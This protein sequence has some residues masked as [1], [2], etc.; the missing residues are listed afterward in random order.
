MPESGYSSINKALFSTASSMTFTKLSKADLLARL[1]SLPCAPL[2]DIKSCPAERLTFDLGSHHVELEMQNRELRESRQLIEQARDRYSDLYDFAPV[3]YLTLD[4]KGFVHEINLTGAEML[5]SN[6]A[7]IIEQ[8]LLR[9]LDSRCHQA[10]YQHMQR[11]FK[12]SERVIDEMV[13]LHG[14]DKQPRHISIL[15]SRIINLLD[16]PWPGCRTAIVDISALKQKEA[17]VTESRRKL[18]QLSAHLDRVRENERRHLAREIHDELGQKLSLARVEASMLSSKLDSQQ[19]D[20]HSAA[21]RV[22][23]RVDDAIASMRAIADDLRPAVLDLGLAAAIRWQVREFRQHSGV[24][25]H[26]EINDDE[27]ELD[28]DRATNIFRIVQESL[29][30]ITRHANAS[31]VKLSLDQRNDS[32]HVLICDNGVGIAENALENP[33]SYGLAGMYERI[34]L[35]DGALKVNSHPGQGTCL[36]IIIPIKERRKKN[37]ERYSSTD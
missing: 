23:Q 36:Q 14:E 16:A 6:S 2:Y 9:W 17:E 20:L 37:S 15:S 4:Q 5:G 29:S 10:F 22:L 24:A 28:N 26:L 25:C 12:S 18:R 32:L 3:G 31:E 34:F 21:E 19:A 7:A 11:V 27:I 13:L 33:S 30:N 35:L 8:P 1:E